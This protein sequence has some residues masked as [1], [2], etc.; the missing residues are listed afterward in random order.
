MADRQVRFTLPEPV[1]AKG[2]W[3]DADDWWINDA[4]AARSVHLQ[5]PG[6]GGF[7]RAVPTVQLERSHRVT[8]G[9]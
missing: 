3:H 9:V 2:P 1:L 8:Y 5:V 4:D 7:V 6:L